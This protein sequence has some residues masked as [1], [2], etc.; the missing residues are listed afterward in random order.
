MC[1]YS[2]FSGDDI[3]DKIIDRLETLYR[4][5]SKASSSLSR[6]A[7]ERLREFDDKI[8]RLIDLYIAKEISQE[9]YQK[10]KAKLLNQKKEL[11]ERLGE[12][13]KTSSG[14]LE[15][16][17]EFVTTC[18]RAGSVAWQG[19]PSAKRDFL[20]IAGSNFILKDRT[21][22]FSYSYPYSFVA[23]SDVSKDWLTEL[24]SYNYISIGPATW[25]RSG[26]VRSKI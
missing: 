8:E 13:E 14:W 1:H 20:K 7:S 19:N 3:K 4:E 24:D 15:P 18:N 23:E 16:A 25:I 12:I 5:E 11:Q 6:Q 9:E 26:V 21:F 17:Q 22:L 2:R 10:N